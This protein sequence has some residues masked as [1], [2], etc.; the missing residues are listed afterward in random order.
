MGELVGLAVVALSGAVLLAW[1][2]ETSIVR[3]DL[4]VGLVFGYM[5]LD[6]ADVPLPV[7]ALGPISVYP[8]DVLTFVLGVA[9]TAR[10]LRLRGLQPLQRLLI[11]LFGLVLF[12]VARGVPAFGI[13]GA[14][15]EARPWLLF[16]VLALYVSTIRPT[17]DQLRRLE[18][19]WIAAGV[20][21]AGLAVLRWGVMIGGIGVPEGP[22]RN[23][24]DGGHPLSVLVAFETFTVATACLLAVTAWLPGG[25]RRRRVIA[26]GLLVVSVLLLHRT[27]WAALVAGLVYLVWTIPQ[28]GRRFTGITLVAGAA[29][30]WLLTGVLGGSPDDIAQ[31]A[32]NE[33]TLDWRVEGWRILLED[34]R[35]STA[36]EWAVGQPFGKGFARQVTANVIDVRPHNLY[37]ETFL[38][39]GLIGLA[40]V[41]ALF[42]R[43]V[44][45]GRAYARV[46][47]GRAGLLPVKLG[48]TLVFA[49][50]YGIGY[51]IELPMAVALGMGIAIVSRRHDGLPADDDSPAIETED[52]T[53]PAL[54]GSGRYTP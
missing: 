39:L 16:V 34:S 53:A 3:P 40:V 33:Q 20:A 23:S 10:L 18:T 24:R 50:V 51:H 1:V 4:P 48:A 32:L 15:D 22:L 12:S 13:E 30:V 9:A 35:P 28:L 17:A 45:I 47:A 37:L 44:L 46:Y 19:I 2:L 25:T 38:R 27:I 7:A 49:A 8:D 41:V 6:F 52:Q 26:T 42:A 21:L 5:V 36:V 11:A 14:V 43:L 29:A 31:D 54:V